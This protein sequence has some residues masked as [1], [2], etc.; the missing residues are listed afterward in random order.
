MTAGL[1]F[2]NQV[3]QNQRQ[4]GI[5]MPIPPKSDRL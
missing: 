5:S 3:D 4:M 1:R 2:S